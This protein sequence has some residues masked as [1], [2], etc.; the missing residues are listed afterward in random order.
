M[1]DTARY[2]LYLAPMPGTSLWQIGSSLLGYDAAEGRDVA[3]PAAFQHDAEHWA[4]LTEDPRRYGFHLTLK[5]PFRLAS[6]KTV[7]QLEQSLADF[8]QGTGSFDLGPLVVE[9]RM[10]SQEHGFVCLV[11]RDPSPELMALEAAAVSRFDR[12][13]AP[14]SDAERAKR[15]PERLPERE[16]NY[17]ETFGYP[18]VLEAFRPHFSL[19][20]AHARPQETAE[21]LST[22]IAGAIGAVGFRCQSIFLF[23]QKSAAERFRVRKIYELCP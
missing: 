20:G 5:A 10:S 1:K 19:T 14:L 22:L 9:C 11:P 17:L 15:K 16:R 8:A 21:K 13:R 6:G 3:F 7:E 18:F 12:F 2:A 4:G 23:E